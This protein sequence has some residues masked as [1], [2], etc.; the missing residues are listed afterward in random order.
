MDPPPGLLDHQKNATGLQIHISRRKPTAPSKRSLPGASNTATTSANKRRH[1]HAPEVNEDEVM[2][3]AALMTK[4]RQRGRAPRRR[5][6][7]NPDDPSKYTLDQLERIRAD[8][9]RLAKRISAA[10]A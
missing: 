9:A 3:L 4:V 6:G 8:T 1:P 7:R 10:L 5:E 2:A